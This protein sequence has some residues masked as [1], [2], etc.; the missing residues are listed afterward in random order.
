MKR[1][2]VK[3]QEVKQKEEKYTNLLDCVLASVE[4]I[5]EEKRKLLSDHSY[6]VWLE[7][8]TLKYP[9]FACS[10]LGCKEQLSDD[11][12]E[13]VKNMDIFFQGISDYCKKYYINILLD[14]DGTYE[15]K[16]IEIKHNGVGY[17]LGYVVVKDVYVYVERKEPQDNAIEFDKILND[18]APEGFEEKR[19]LLTQFEQLVTEMK[20]KQIPIYNLLEIVNNY[21]PTDVLISFINKL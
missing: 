10:T 20:E 11:D 7:N 15:E 18:I 19:S 9:F 14:D 2:D 6:I 17:R 5:N 21:F 8:F 1:K 3:K 16:R 13:H 12:K 4:R